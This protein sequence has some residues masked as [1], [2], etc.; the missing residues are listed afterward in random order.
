MAMPKPESKVQ[1][2]EI[3]HQ[4][5]AT[6]AAVLSHGSPTLKLTHLC[7]QCLDV[8]Q[9][10]GPRSLLDLLDESEGKEKASEWVLVF[11]MRRHGPRQT[12]RAIV[13]KMWD[14]YQQGGWDMKTIEGHIGRI[15][16]C[17]TDGEKMF[18]I[19]TGEPGT[20]SWPIQ[21]KRSANAVGCKIRAEYIA[22][23]SSGQT[24]TILSRVWIAN[25]S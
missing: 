13:E 5:E 21:G 19:S 2:C 6:S 16:E 11:E 20:S 22:F 15:F 17:P 9:N 24:Y 14:A 8:E 25:E 12:D 18:D 23:G 10:K 7:Q 1:I 3:C 4:Q